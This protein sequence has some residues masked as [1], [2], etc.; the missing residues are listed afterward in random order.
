MEKVKNYM[1]IKVLYFLCL[2]L[3]LKL[4]RKKSITVIYKHSDIKVKLSEFWR[5]YFNNTCIE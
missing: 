2:P 3:I 4:Q 5:N 1:D